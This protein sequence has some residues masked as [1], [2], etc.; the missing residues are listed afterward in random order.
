M[1]Q[2]IDII[3]KTFPGDYEW[4]PF[5]WK[6]LAKYATGWR[7][8]VV[9]VEEQYEAPP[10]PERAR[11]V[12][13]RRYEGTECSAYNGVAIERLGAW[14]HSDADVLL[15]VD[16]DCVFCRPVDFQTDPT[17]MRDGKPVVL[18]GD[19]DVSLPQAKWLNIARETLG[20]E[21]WHFTMM[22][23]PFVFT[24]DTMRSC[25]DHCG[26]EERL[27]RT[28]VTDWEVVGNFALRCDSAN[29]SPEAA[30]DAG[31]ACVWQFWGKGGVTHPLT[32]EDIE[33]G[34]MGG[35]VRN[36]GVQA[37]MRELGLACA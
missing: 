12:R 6:S 31:P 27:V 23:Y 14:R 37:K 2:T 19:R 33:V 16:S 1:S 22:R 8:I 17:I 34:K 32:Q 10:L 3:V 18:W 7:E 13:C 30:R 36:P 9:I 24:R 26:G 11:L 28:H 5:L 15:F 25:W 21:P 4:L 20:F 29:C 35:G